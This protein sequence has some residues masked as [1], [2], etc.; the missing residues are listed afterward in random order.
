MERNDFIRSKWERGMEIYNQSEL[1][2]FKQSESDAGT[3]I[4]ELVITGFAL[5]ALLLSLY[6]LRACLRIAC[7]LMLRRDLP[8]TGED[9]AT[10]TVTDYRRASQTEE[11]TVVPSTY[12]GAMYRQPGENNDR[13]KPLIISAV[14]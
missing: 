14:L 3:L 11:P 1:Q 12:T 6:F 2:N 5:T 13:N 10:T 7:R 8:R 9:S 4:K